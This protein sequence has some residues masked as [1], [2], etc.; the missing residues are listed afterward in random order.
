MANQS[1]SVLVEDLGTEENPSGMNPLLVHSPILLIDLT[2]ENNTEVITEHFSRSKDS[3]QTLTLNNSVDRS[4]NEIPSNTKSLSVDELASLLVDLMEGQVSEEVAEH[5]PSQGASGGLCTPNQITG[6]HITEERRVE[7][8]APVTEH[9]GMGTC[10]RVFC[11]GFQ[12]V[13]N[14]SSRELTPGEISLLSKGY[15]FV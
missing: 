3:D 5:L 14:L 2:K 9:V 13:V 6:E 11:D 10:N 12:V 7:V 1:M 8:E 15:H 4:I